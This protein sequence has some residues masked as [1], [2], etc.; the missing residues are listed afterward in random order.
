MLNC[1]I[2]S[3][4]RRTIPLICLLWVALP[5]PHAGAV[6]LDSSFQYAAHAH[7][8]SSPYGSSAVGVAH[9]SAG[10]VIA[11]GRFSGTTDFDSG[12]EVNALTATE[13]QS[14]FIAKYAVDGSFIWA[15]K[16]APN[17]ASGDLLLYG[18]HVDGSGDIFIF[19]A[20]IGT[21][22]MDPGPAVHTIVE[23]DL[24][25]GYGPGDFDG[26][27]AKYSA[28]G[29]YQWAFV[30]GTP[31]PQCGQGCPDFF[32]S[33]VVTDPENDVYV[34]GTFWNSALFDC[35]FDPGS[36]VAT[37]PGFGVNDV[38]LAKYS[39]SGGF[40]DAITFG[41]TGDD[42]PS[43]LRFTSDGTLT[44]TGGFT[45][46]PDFDAGDGTA[47][48]AANGFN[49]DPFAARYTQSL[50]LVWVVGG[51]ASIWNESYSPCAEDSEGN[52]YLISGIVDLGTQTDFDPGPGTTIF[53]GQGNGDIVFLKL[54]PT[55]SFVWARHLATPQYEGGL[56]VQVD[57]A[58]NP[59]FVFR[60]YG[61]LDLDPGPGNTLIEGNFAG[62]AVAQYSPAGE[63]LAVHDF[64]GL[65]YLNEFDVTG[66]HFLNDSTLLVNGRLIGTTDVDPGPDS[67]LV[68]SANAPAGQ[69]PTLFPDWLLTTLVDAGTP[70]TGDLGG[71]GYVDGADLGALL[72]AWGVCRN[73][74]ADLDG[75]GEVGGG[76]LGILLAAWSE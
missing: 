16:I 56:D 65:N 39:S 67:V 46:T 7:I 53:T 44:V 63:L 9:D 21:V 11:A 15:R 2:R 73:C 43:G 57:G 1:P 76:D 47:T 32:V 69:F 41:G 71:D 37:R 35:D 29:E 3:I 24:A 19:G 10:N 26:F 38:F 14:I 5:S 75:D 13:Y 17:Q 25:N 40:V 42:F 31:V 51:G 59:W 45:G 74:P 61:S 55:G 70:I 49:T 52:L 68:T 33:G 22:D 64:S 50:E 8:P 28:S 62:H 30:I 4:A 23:A 12:P 18:V 36:G 48:L 58:G 60:F 6:P 66:I 27:V 34:T 54:D 72:G 20:M